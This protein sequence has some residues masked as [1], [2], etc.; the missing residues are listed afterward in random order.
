MNRRIVT[1]EVVGVAAPKGSTRAFMPKG[2][3][4]PVVTHD[5]PRTRGWQHLVADGA[6]RVAGD[7]LFVGPVALVVTFHL[8]RPKSLPR[9]V[10]H[11]TTA[12][13]LDKLVRCTSDALT[14]ILYADD[15]QVVDLE[16]HKV[17]AA[18]ASPPRATITLS[19]AEAPAAEQ[20]FLEG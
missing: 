17:Y 15:S 2:G 3:K 14:G 10:R 6:Q 18:I 12:P 8:P 9:R 1:F 7:G 11:V 13:D 4:Y 5:N 20:L 19:E 16:A